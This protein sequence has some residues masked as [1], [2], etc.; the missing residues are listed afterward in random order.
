MPPSA[1]LRCDAA[2]DADVIAAFRRALRDAGI[3]PPSEIIA[4]GRPHRYATTGDRP[5]QRA[6]AYVLHQDG[7]PAG[8][9]RDWRTSREWRGALDVGRNGT[10][11]HNGD[12][13]RR[14]VVLLDRYRDQQRTREKLRRMWHAAFD[15]E[16]THAYL[17]RKSVA[18][19]GIRQLGNDLLVPAH[20]AAGELVGLQRITPDSAKRWVRGSAPGGACLALTPLDGASFISIAEGYATAASVPAATGDSS[21]AAV[22]AFSRENLPA[23][24]R[25]IRE[26]HPS[27]ALLI[28][29][30][31]DANDNGRSIAVAH[32]AAR[33]VRGFV[34]TPPDGMDL[35]DV[36]CRDGADAVQRLLAEAST[37]QSERDSESQSER[38]EVESAP[39]HADESLR[40][41]TLADI[42]DSPPRDL[43]FG[44]LEPDGPTAMYGAGGVGKGTTSVWIISQCI[45]E[46]LRPL[47]YDA[48]QRPREWARRASGLGID[49]TRVVY[50]QPS[51]LPQTLRGKPMWEVVP[52]LGR[53]AARAGCDILFVDSILASMNLSEEG[54]KSDAAAPYR[55]VSAV[56]ALGIPSVSIGHTPKNA[57]EGDPYGSVSWVNAMRLTWLGT[58]AE[59]EGHRVRWTPR[60]RNERGHIPAVLLAFDYDEAGRLCGVTRADDEESTRQWVLDA[61]A[62]G[63]LTVEEMAD[64]LAAQSDQPYTAAVAR[65]KERLRQTLNRM[66]RS[67]LVHKSGGRGTPW[68]LGAAPERGGRR[69]A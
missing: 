56:D 65:A 39:D 26:Q 34:V 51:D 13:E 52:H 46:G 16:P 69:T 21:I 1:D 12:A 44:M 22:C 29:A 36:L 55:Y 27:A 43:L 28:I 61:L 32:E 8:W 59:G 4:D 53:I 25:T 23:V 60:K 7:V 35:N 50:V 54:L 33:G 6:G 45:A 3:D 64:E 17:R 24:A 9:A 40:Y 2:T 11:S 5:G 19:H 62:R 49:R 10:A 58:R 41:S 68:A 57:P 38:V 47:V 37:P 15:P 63:P 67:G 18:A 30:D 66:K 14:H 20:N 48:E 31:A 42:D